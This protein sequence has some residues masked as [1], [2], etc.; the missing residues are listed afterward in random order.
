MDRGTAAAAAPADEALAG[1]HAVMVDHRFP[2]AAS[3]LLLRASV[4]AVLD[5]EG[6]APEE[7]RALVALAA[8]PVF[9]RNGL[10]ICTGE[11]DPE[12]GLARVEAPRARAVGVT[13]GGEGSLWRV[14]GETFRI[15]APRL[16]MRDTTGCGDVFHGAFALAIAEERRLP[17]AIRFATAAAALKGRNGAGWR[18][19]ASRAEVAALLR[20]AW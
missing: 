5:A 12:R 17:D 7:L 2:Q 16:A 13:L 8:Y 9:S 10:L 6:G 4:P 11:S 15:G 18:G 1:V 14:A 20:E 19:M 3:A